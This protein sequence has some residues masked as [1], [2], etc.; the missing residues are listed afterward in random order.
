MECPIIEPRV[1]EQ[2]LRQGGRVVLPGFGTFYTS[3]R[4]AGTVRH[5]Q[6]GKPVSFPARRVAAFRTGEVLKRAVR[7]QRRGRPKKRF[8]IL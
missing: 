4:Q 5:I 1:I 2:T 6:S 8:G 3:E 7:G